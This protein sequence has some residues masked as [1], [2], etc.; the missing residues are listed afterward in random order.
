MSKKFQTTSPREHI[1]FVAQN[2]CI[3]LGGGGGG[4]SNKVVKRI[5]KFKFAFLA[6]FLF[7]CSFL[8]V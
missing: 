1:R 4:V 6:I 3:L 7:V 5:L 2:S 8:F